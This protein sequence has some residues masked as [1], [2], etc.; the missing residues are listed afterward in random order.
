[1]KRHKQTYIPGI[2]GT[3][4]AIRTAQDDAMPKTS[5]WAPKPGEG[6]SECDQRLRTDIREQQSRMAHSRFGM[7]LRPTLGTTDAPSPF[8]AYRQGLKRS[9]GL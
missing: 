8:S 1:M 2:G 9:L 7:I 6:V 3:A 5:W 4:K